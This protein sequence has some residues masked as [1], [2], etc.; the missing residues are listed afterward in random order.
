MR[1]LILFVGIPLLFLGL[2][3]HGYFSMSNSAYLDSFSSEKSCTIHLSKI[4]SPEFS[5]AGCPSQIILVQASSVKLFLGLG[6]FLTGAGA[7]LI[8][9]EIDKK[10]KNKN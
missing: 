4:S 5:E 9:S 6:V 2:I 1:K 10:A 8:Y 7:F 3:L